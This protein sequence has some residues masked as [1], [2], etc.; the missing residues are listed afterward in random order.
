M[1]CAPPI[2][3]PQRP[4]PRG[5]SALFPASFL[6]STVTDEPEPEYAQAMRPAVFDLDQ[7]LIRAE[8]LDWSLWLSTITEALGVNCPSRKL[9]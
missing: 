4:R 5:P 6:Y 8:A 7:T 1:P 2:L 9:W 3:I